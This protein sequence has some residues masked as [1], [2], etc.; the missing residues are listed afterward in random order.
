MPKIHISIATLPQL[1]AVIEIC[2]TNP[3]NKLSIHSDLLLWLLDERNLFQIEFCHTIF[4]NLREILEFIKENNIELAMTFPSVVRFSTVERLKKLLF[5]S[6]ND[7]ISKYFTQYFAGNLEILGLLL[8]MRE[9]YLD[10]QQ[11][12]RMEQIY[13]DYSLYAF[14][15]ESRA[16]LEQFQ[17]S[18][19]CLPY[20]WSRHEMKTCFKNISERE[21]NGI[22]CII[23]G[24][25]PLMESAGCV[26][27][28]TG[29][30]VKDK[31][32]EKG[33]SLKTLYLLDRY[34]KQLP[35]VIHCDR[36][37]NTIYNTVPFSLH[38]ELE[39]LKKIGIKYFR[40]Q[41]TI[42]T[43]EEAFAILKGYFPEN[44]FTKGHFA[45]GVE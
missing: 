38:K 11:K 4:C 25:I 7:W 42:E 5:V 18:G 35:V 22:E 43:K 23:Y 32:L 36:C 41:F 8:K 20:E 34:K 6:K 44:E 45:K 24:Y 28:T 15:G 2:E 12:W 40:F 13:A 27:E 19:F 3:P 31:K 1:E 21:A 30:C 37:E 39:A 16:F 9:G 26:L 17:I 14:N 10:G 29:N 33:R